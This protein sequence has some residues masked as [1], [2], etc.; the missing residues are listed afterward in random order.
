MPSRTD[1]LAVNCGFS[2]GDSEL[3][4]W[5]DDENDEPCELNITTRNTQLYAK[6]QI[7][8]STI[9]D[10]VYLSKKEAECNITSTMRDSFWL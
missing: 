4:G 5:S 8:L 2:F 3:A 10:G 6:M 7:P 9:G 1:L